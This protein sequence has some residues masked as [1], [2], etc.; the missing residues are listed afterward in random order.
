[1]LKFGM[2]QEARDSMKKM[3]EADSKFESLQTKQDVS[4]LSYGNE[5]FSVL[6]QTQD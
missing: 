3:Q 1:M 5:T 6:P 2:M 4:T